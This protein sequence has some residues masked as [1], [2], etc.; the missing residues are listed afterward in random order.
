M[1][2]LPF[3]PSIRLA[4]HLLLR[5]GLSLWVLVPMVTWAQSLEELAQHL[6]VSSPGLQALTYEQQAA[7]ERVPQVRQLPQPELGVGWFVLPVETRLGAQQLRMGATQ[8]LPWPGTLNARESLAQTQAERVVHQRAARYQ[9]ELYQL[10]LAYFQLT[11]TRLAQAFL[12]QRATLLRSLK[13]IVQQKVASGQATLAQALAVDIQL[14]ELEQ[15]VHVFRN[16]ERLPMATLHQLL[17]DATPDSLRTPDALALPVLPYPADTLLAY[18]TRQHPLVKGERVEQSIAEARR[19]VN[20][21]E[22]RPK[23]GLGIDYVQVVPRTDA[24]PEANGRDALQVRASI[25]LPLYRKKYQAIDREQQL[26]SRASQQRQQAIARQLTQQVEQAYAQWE[27]ARLLHE[28]YAQQRQAAESALKVMQATYRSESTGFETLL[29]FHHDL[30]GY[31][32]GML[33]AKVMALKAK[34]R[35]ESLMP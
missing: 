14:Q 8:M 18:L 17:G 29:A 20:Q 10:Q 15:Q 21:Y 28:L 9:D 35:L 5:V 19:L 3:F 25:T 16:R 33:Q 22:G 32:L 23:L 4:G 26:K 6:R 24:M 27:E 13:G 34:A 11:E 12:R 7:L 30:I 1:I 31:E 2:Q